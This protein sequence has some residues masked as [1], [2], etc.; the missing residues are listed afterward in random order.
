MSEQSFRDSLRAF[1]DRPAQPSFGNQQSGGFKLGNILQGSFGD[2]SGESL[3]D[4]FRNRTQNLVS[5]GSWSNEDQGFFAMTRFQRIVT[6]AACMF[7]ALLCFSLAFFTLP[8]IPIRPQK[9]ALAFSMG[10]L[11]AFAGIAILQGPWEYI[12]SI[13]APDRLLFTVSYFGSMILTLFF[14]MNGYYFL[15]IIASIIELLA[16]I[17]YFISYIPGGTSGLGYV[18]QYFMRNSV[19]LPI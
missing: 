4:N 12:K 14:A 13:T 10:S 15:T 8:M 19:G 11:L 2:G 6:C 17:S 5:G 3:L 16:L 7:F 1:H 18:S 9:F